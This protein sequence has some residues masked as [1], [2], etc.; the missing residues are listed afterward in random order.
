MPTSNEN[1]IKLK[2]YSSAMSIRSF[3]HDCLQHCKVAVL[4]KTN[5]KVLLLSKRN[6]HSFL[7]GLID[8]E[9]FFITAHNFQF[10]ISPG[11]NLESYKYYFNNQ[12]Y[13][14]RTKYPL[15]K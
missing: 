2:E 15:L 14:T 9:Q 5:S 6:V 1:W 4:K 12:M 3:Y 13:Y 7:I 10:N 11:T 8:Y